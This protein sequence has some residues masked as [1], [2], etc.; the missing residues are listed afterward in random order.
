MKVVASSLTPY[1][2]VSKRN[3]NQ[4]AHWLFCFVFI[5]SN[6]L[7]IQQATQTKFDPS[8]FF[9]ILPMLKVVASP[10]S[11]YVSEKE[12][13]RA[14]MRVGREAWVKGHCDATDLSVS[15]EVRTRHTGVCV[16]VFLA[17][18][19]LLLLHIFITVWKGQTT[20]G[21]CNNS[22]SRPQQQQMQGW[23][24]STQRHSAH[25]V[26]HKKSSSTLSESA[27]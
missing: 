1:I 20:T 4:Y 11:V 10:T 18:L 14:N 3:K 17:I 13:R 9:P 21:T 12:K 19:L 16:I 5:Q 2:F 26:M 22:K 8:S 7:Y 6:I 27:K 15:E 24:Y 25:A 23:C